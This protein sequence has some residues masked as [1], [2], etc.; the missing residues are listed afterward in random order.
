MVTSWGDA[1]PLWGEASPHRVESA[2]EASLRSGPSSSISQKYLL[3]QRQT[4]IPAGGRFAPVRFQTGC[5][6]R[7]VGSFHR[8]PLDPGCWEAI[9]RG[10][11][12][13]VVASAFM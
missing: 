13:L 6:S 5:A 9:R 1:N 3:R 12:L 10:L 4:A 7:F 8:R 2:N 11:S